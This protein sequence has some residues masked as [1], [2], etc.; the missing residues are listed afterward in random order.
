MAES[1]EIENYSSRIYSVYTYAKENWSEKA[2]NYFWPKIFSSKFTEHGKK[3]EQ[4]ALNA[5]KKQYSLCEVHTVGFVINKRYP[6]FGYSPDG[7][8]FENGK[9]IKLLEIKCPYSG[10]EN[11]APKIL[12]ECNYLERRGDMWLLKR[13]HLYYGQV[14]FGMA[15]LNVK[16]TDFVIY[17]SATNTFSIIM[18]EFDEEFARS[19]I[20]KSN[21]M[22]FKNMIHCYCL[23]KN[24][25]EN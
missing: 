14:Q 10:K 21:E 18:V 16:K 11:S 8:I 17:A 24:E 4:H 6:W 23:N 15:L 22:Y 1:Q 9:P 19:L 2:I 12:E 20:L 13:K 5:Y 7:I 25:F 3:Y